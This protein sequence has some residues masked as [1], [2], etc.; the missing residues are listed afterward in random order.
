MST[1]TAN[2]KPAH[3]RAVG[4]L[5][6]LNPS[7]IFGLSVVVTF[8]LALYLSERSFRLY[9]TPKYL[10]PEHIWIAFSAWFCLEVGRRI[11]MQWQTSRGDGS[12]RIEKDVRWWFFASFALTVAAYGILLLRGL[13]NGL[14]L[15]VIKEN[16]FAPPNDVSRE[17]A[18][19]VVIYMPGITT[20]TQFGIIC[21]LLGLWLDHRGLRYVRKYVA[22]IVGLAAM[23]ALLFHERLALIE[24]LV[25]AAVLVLRQKWLSRPL[26]PTMRTM[27]QIGPVLGLALMLVMFGGFEY[28]RSW[29]HYRH[30]FTSFTEFT[31]W[32]IGGYYST[33]QNNGALGW[34]R[35]GQRPLPF[36]TLYAWWEFPPVEK[37]PL[38]YP[39]LAGH[40]PTKAHPALLQQYAN[41]EYNSPGGLFEPL[42][43]WGPLGSLIWW[44]AYGALLGWA[45]RGYLEGSLTGLVLFPIALLS[46][47][48][49]PRFIYIA[50]PRILAPLVVIGWLHYRAWVANVGWTSGPTAHVGLTPRRSPTLQ[51][52]GG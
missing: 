7:W 12:E 1:E 27:F 14:S 3:W 19:E 33:S 11:G 44:T 40:D 45:Y 10:K 5:W 4:R 18:G 15:S 35:E 6:W 49:L 26:S 43:D 41:L 52:Q 2:S 51:S 16:L 25:P 28:F 36:A 50:H 13:Q 17:L 8:L 23:R 34:E 32:R 42:R 39:K 47:L 46:L 37:S 38:A 24:V 48:E 9:E 29:R 21:V 22:V 30:E 20:A 31:V